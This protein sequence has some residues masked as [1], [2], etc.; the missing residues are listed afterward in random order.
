MSAEIVHLPGVSLR[1]IPA[2][3]RGLADRIEAGEYG[4]VDTLFALMP[5]GG[6]FPKMWGWGD[7]DGKN[8]PVIQLQL[9]LHW[10]IT[11]MTAHDPPPGDRA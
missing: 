11:H 8:D 7:V 6:D 2:Q 10:H 1:D 5:C 4:E 3:L 9:A